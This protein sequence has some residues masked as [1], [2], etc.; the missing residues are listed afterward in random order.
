MGRASLVVASVIGLLSCGGGGASYPKVCDAMRAQDESLLADTPACDPRTEPCVWAA[1]GHHLERTMCGGVRKR[2][3]DA[4]RID[5]FERTMDKAGCGAVVP[6]SCPPPMPRPTPTDTTTCDELGWDEVAVVE[7][8]PC[9]DLPGAA[10]PT[11]G[12]GGFIYATACGPI[13]LS[14]GGV[15]AMAMLDAHMASSGCPKVMRGCWTR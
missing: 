2:P 13:K 3:A 12:I 6:S 5:A 14:A 9:V 15:A 10:C 8:H 11:T 4:Q 1:M 7:D